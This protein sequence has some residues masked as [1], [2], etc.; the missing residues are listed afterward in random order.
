MLHHRVL[1]QLDDSFDPSHWDSVISLQNL[2]VWGK[3]S[4]SWKTADEERLIEALTQAA[5]WQDEKLHGLNESLT[6]QN[7]SLKSTSRDALRPL[8]SSSLLAERSSV[9]KSRYLDQVV[10]LLWAEAEIRILADNAK[11]SIEVFTPHVWVASWMV[12]MNLDSLFDVHLIGQA[13]QSNGSPAGIPV[14]LLG[15]AYVL[16]NTLILIK[17]IIWLWSRFFSRLQLGSNS[18]ATLPG[19]ADVLFLD[20]F[21]DRSE[22]GAG[23]AKSKY[24]STLPDSL[25]L[26]GHKV[27]FAHIFVPDNRVRTIRK[28]Q[29]FNHENF[30][31]SVFIEGFLGIADHI[32]AMAVMVEIFGAWLA[33][34]RREGLHKHPS[35]GL[36]IVRNREVAVS[37]FGTIGAS[38]ILYEYAFKELAKESSNAGIRKLVYVCEFQGWETRLLENFRAH[39]IET[40][41]YCHSTLRLLDAR[42]YLPTSSSM[43]ALS[44]VRPD[45]LAAHSKMD[46][47]R[48]RFRAGQARVELVESTR[49]K[50]LT[51]KIVNPRRTNPKKVLVVG[52]Y[53]HAETAYLVMTCQKALELAPKRYRFTFLSHPNASVEPSNFPT[54]R[55]DPA[56]SFSDLLSDFDAAVV[57]PETSGAM[58]ALILGLKVVIIAEPGRLVASPIYGL[59]G[60]EI[61]REAEDLFRS[62]TKVETPKPAQLAR[63]KP[64][65]PGKEGFKLWSDLLKDP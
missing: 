35:T 65:T 8:L 39:E 50:N 54:L 44:D 48:L 61:V 52:G 64:I 2:K 58:E 20:Y 17:G 42:G 43:E 5:R 25:R 47:W 18:R 40:I 19:E 23:Q 13:K 7:M 49:Y 10:Q 9:H 34:S 11:Y 14:F 12:E 56:R 45:V 59:P 1:V 16:K 31:E 24:W 41:G 37:L 26:R 15:A 27:T 38:N 33:H 60:V 63:L 55:R 36:E 22:S 30:V 57:A 3:K 29:K 46:E 32:R 28:A 53:S 4:Q 62:L 6:T 51:S 21:F